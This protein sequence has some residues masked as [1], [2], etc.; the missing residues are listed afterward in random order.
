[1]K[2]KKKKNFP[3]HPDSS[4]IDDGVAEIESESYIFFAN[5]MFTLLTRII[6]KNNVIVV[7]K[8][9]CQC[10]SLGLNMLASTRQE[11]DLNEQ[12]A[13]LK[14]Y[15]KAE[16]KRT[17]KQTN[18]TNEAVTTVKK[19]KRQE[20]IYRQAVQQQISL[21]K[22]S[23]RD[24]AIIENMRAFNSDYVIVNKTAL[25]TVYNIAN[26]YVHYLPGET[27]LHSSGNCRIRHIAEFDN[28]RC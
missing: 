16:K 23:I 24:S 27:G 26:S 4:S 8:F 28:E 9:T 7:I 25:V 11:K 20:N 5:N 2:R 18:K 10:Y 1:M 14:S 6:S 3:S 15:V 17:V 12:V 21:G 22:K 19:K 13:L